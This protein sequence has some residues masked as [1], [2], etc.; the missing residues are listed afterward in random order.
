[1]AKQVLLFKY[2]DKGI[3]NVQA[4]PDRAEAFLAAAQKLGIK[5]EKF[6][7]ITGPYDCLAIVDAPNDEA[8]ASLGLGTA[9]LGNVSTCTC[10]A[11]DSAEFRKIVEKI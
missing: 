11:Y 8:T 10:R 3:A 5:V 6:L 4:S 1:M 9:K 7:W 2:T